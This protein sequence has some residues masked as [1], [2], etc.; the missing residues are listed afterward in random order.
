MILEIVARH[1]KVF[2]SLMLLLL[3]FETI[4]P[5]YALGIPHRK[6]VPVRL[7]PSFSEKR[8][9]QKDVSA[10]VP[11]SRKTTGPS[12]IGGP[13]Q[14]ESQAFHSVNNENMVDLFSG[15]FSYSI[16]LLDIGGYPLAIGYNS[17]ISMDEEASWVGLGWNINP[18]AITRNMRGL[19]D[20]FDGTDTIQKVSSIK[21]NKTVGVTV[22]TGME[23]FGTPKNAKDS[24]NSLSLSA[25]LGISHNTYKGL[26][27]ETGLNASINA[28]A[29][30]MGTFT[31]GLSF[32][33]SSR[34][35][36]TVGTSLAYSL[37]NKVSEENMSGGALSVSQGLAYN[38]RTGMKDLQF[39]LGTR[40]YQTMK[41]NNK[42]HRSGS[43]FSSGTSFVH[44]SFTP[45]I[46]LPYTSSLISV[47]GKV[48]G[49]YRGFMRN[50]YI[51]GYVTKQEIAEEDKHLALPAYGYL[52]YQLANGNDGALLDFNREKEIPYRE[53]PAVP[54][55]GI[56]SYTYDVFAVSGEGTGGVFRAYRGDIG[57]VHDHSIK[58]KDKSDRFSGDLGLG[59]L[60]HVGL[61]LNVNRSF[62]QTGPWKTF[63][64]LADNIR[65]RK[66]DKNFEAVY[67]RN[68]G[69]TTV[70]TGAFYG[71]I[72][73]DDVVAVELYQAGN[74]SSMISTTNLLNRY[75]NGKFAGSQEMSPRNNV[76]TSRDKRT[77]VISYLT[78]EESSVAG[79]SKYIENYRLNQY[80]LH[81]CDLSF[82]EEL[83]ADRHGLSGEYFVGNDFQKFHYARIDS[84]INF[85]NLN[86]VN[87]GLP[88]GL[89]KFGRRWSARW[90]GRLKA[91]VTGAYEIVTN[92]D[93]G[94]R[95]S[96]ND[97]MFIDRWNIHPDKPDTAFVNLQAGQLYN[98]KLEYYQETENVTIRL[99]WRYAG[100]PLMPIP[101]SNL[102][103]MPS[104]DTVTVQG[105]AISL[106]KR[107]NTFRKKN[108][109]SEVSV[110][111]ADGRRYVYGL[112][113]YSLKQ[114][115]KTFSVNA[116]DGN[117]T[118]GLVKYT[119]GVD[120]AVTNQKG[121]DWYF[122]SE[123]VPAYAHSF[124]LTGLMSPDYVDLTGD[125]ISDDDPGSAVKFNYT[126]T[127][128]I[129][130]PYR[131][132]A[133]SNDSATYN[134]GLRTDSRDDKGSYIYGEKELWYVNSIESKNMIATFKL[135]D[136]DD[137]LAIDEKG[138][139]YPGAAK[140]LDE[141]NLYVK[142]DFQKYG[143]A[144]A[145]PVKTVHFE[146]SYDL[147]KGV[148]NAK[149][150]TTGKLTLKRIWFTYNGNR[151]GERNPYI[152]NY[153][154][155]NPSYNIRSYDRWGNYKD[156][157]QNPGSSIAN[158]ITNAEYPY[159]LQDSTLAAQNAAAWTLDSIKLPSGGRIKVDYES[160]DYAFVQNRRAAQ[161]FRIA[162]FSGSEPASSADLKPKLYSTLNE[163]L[164]VSVDVPKAV[165][166]KKELYARYL[167]GM[168]TLFFRLYVE[169]PADKFGK[170][171]EYVSCYAN[172][173]PGNYG[174]FND[175]RTIWFKMKAIT[176]NGESDKVL[177]IYSP[178]AKASRQFLRLNL[179]SK[180]Y[181]GSDVGNDV[182]LADAVK[183]LMSQAGNV[184]DML[185]T[186]ENAARIKGWANEVDLTRCMVRLNNPYHK[187]YGGGLRV[188]RI[189]IY[190]H[191]NA[192][193]K[194]KESVYGH[195]YQYVTSRIVNGKNETISSGVAGFEPLI[196][197]E[198][199]PW[200]L[201]L[202]YKEQVAAMAPVATGYTEK[203]LG[204]SFYPAPS[205][206]YSKV[207]IRT[208][209][210][211]NTRSA[212]GFEEVGFYT[213]Y[214]FPTLTDMTL[215]A[216]SKKRF[217]PALSN[218]LRINARHFVAISQGFKVELNDMNG[219]MR[220]T[221]Y[222]SESDPDVPVSS[223]ENFYKVD[224]ENAIS[225][226]LNNTVMA[227]DPQ[228]VIDT[229]AT[230]G[231]DMELMLDIREQRSVTNAVNLNVNTDNFTF[232]MPPVFIVP[233]LLNLAQREETKF[234]SV[235]A[236]KII[237]RH[238]ILD[239]VVVIDKGSKISTRNLLF[240]SE[241]GNVI[242]A[243][244]QNEFDDPVYSF[245][246]P[247]GWVYD[248][249]SGAYKNINT[250][251]EHVY[252][253][254][255]RIT[256]GPGLAKETEYFSAGDEIL[257]GSRE[258]TGGLDC[259]PEIATFR[260]FGV[261]YAV[262]ANVMSG[263]TPDIYFADRDGKPF[264]GNDIAMKVI[265]S[266]RRN[267]SAVVGEIT[268]LANP[269]KK[270]ATG[271][272][273][274]LD[275][276]IKAVSASA[277]DFSQF[278]KGSDK[279]VQRIETTCLQVPYAEYAGGNGCGKHYYSNKELKQSFTRSDCPR[280][281]VAGEPVEFIVPSGSH[282]SDISQEDADAKA[283]ADMAMNGQADAD[284]RGV[285]RPYYFSAP[286]YTEFTGI[287][288]KGKAGTIAFTYNQE[289]GTDSSLIS[290]HVAD[291]LAWIKAMRDGQTYANAHT[292]CAYG[293][294]LQTGVL[295]KN[296]CSAGG[297][298]SVVSYTIPAGTFE[299]DIS[300]TDANNK[301]FAAAQD[302][303]NAKGICTYSSD[304][305]YGYF[306]KVCG[307]GGATTAVYHEL[308]AGA[309]TS[310]IS[311]DDANAKA[312]ARLNAEGQ[313]K[314]NTS[315]ICTYNSDPVSGVFY[316]TCTVGGTS[317]AVNHSLP[318]GAET[319]T[320]NKEDA[321]AK[322]QARLNTE[323]LALANANAVCS[324]PN[325]PQTASATRSCQT[326]YGS[327]PVSYTVA[328][329]T[330][331]VNTSLA[332]ANSQALQLA[333]TKAQEKAN[334]EGV[335][336]PLPIYVYMSTAL[337]TPVSGT[338]TATVTLKFYYDSAGT[339]PA[340]VSN[341]KVNYTYYNKDCD[342]DNNGVT[343]NQSI[344]CTGT[345]TVIV[346]DQVV[347]QTRNG[348]LCIE[349]RYELSAGTGYIK[350]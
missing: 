251:L 333:T 139:K 195:E 302:S 14:P 254:Q 67:F 188:K 191:W 37:S 185:L 314:A 23:I 98:I 336:S 89:N 292:V 155:H 279:K 64:P 103:L 201:P 298:G 178:L 304:F 287:C 55:I 208:I 107:V 102:Y 237:N 115:E 345:Q 220:S 260:S 246:I 117:E 339:Q 112:P 318:A 343:T 219:R 270:T 297:V 72:G 142:A 334:A 224:N 82:P 5:S 128:G 57:Y 348:T 122:N 265:R 162:G 38:T 53:K 182:D 231:K 239:S 40:Q 346:K 281:F 156:P 198:E 152:F 234:Q 242:L 324:Y 134:K 161:M 17:G 209:H 225:R 300:V 48:G 113:V 329:G 58:T 43:G 199:N 342:V 211:K 60:V 264:S 296:N 105:G 323:G 288:P 215:L 80:S 311:K 123:E 119:H 193:T 174:Y 93:D 192:M 158:V 163:Y 46:T 121:N 226:H 41:R 22:G 124:L 126:K 140:K 21:E 330:I 50:L 99:R 238:G 106:E 350:M 190:D 15:D 177:S 227:I 320:I 271:Y 295:T 273:L 33:N 97:T 291:S 146:Y 317:T 160:D 101:S 51:S 104:K 29:K 310:V 6:N 28:G 200:R 94:V 280:G 175:G 26:G 341:L 96:I 240:D 149:D 45:T 118:D 335:C 92:S 266:G 319:S 197:G 283:A 285:C 196:G 52:N 235:G 213:T 321:N 204:E 344:N 230:M 136:R 349:R 145:R 277:G 16:P 286:I 141:I 340:S 337:F 184:V 100:L 81:N 309:E 154:S 263:G 42:V 78:A 171:K 284:T 290:Q 325:Q 181:P 13:G 54:N 86:A 214:D 328:A 168:D 49:E 127:A 66:S 194:Q 210:A 272:T 135:S 170:G 250:T 312:Q 19:P 275:S 114:K 12:D 301:A 68:P 327:T 315:G 35:G 261:V 331:V 79:L 267:I 257:V 245:N 189:R 61:D 11:V 228:G 20:D 77:Q 248:G 85:P 129:K 166:S 269:M 216:D 172:I 183:M 203:P 186:Y 169:M 56:P 221:A 308:A 116:A 255:G 244:T 24:S 180:A 153:N 233:M 88:A 74:S 120:D 144:G 282:Y 111:N 159:A 125:G 95:L 332:D 276:T 10:V 243:R 75:R 65:F 322:A 59:D 148:N 73:G 187:K 27:L 7:V 83:D 132:R 241:T 76:K 289:S 179:P 4:I 36:I 338:R 212:N 70:N 202:A 150:I 303:A 268:S 44:P 9:R 222:Y 164:Y 223:T 151:K 218:F 71:N 316:K 91:D 167:E 110:L 256:S 31:T 278:W 262:D 2:A 8:T 109:I 63:N 229:A 137:Q 176:E 133:P 32:T 207:R 47:T 34:D 252:I 90:T 217:K 1:K 236:T 157:L 69:E 30:G 87:A 307:T 274:V 143:P 253:R 258:R 306:T 165:N 3:Y 147:C 232:P 249:M 294:E 313:S 293:N 206:G 62:T 326:G 131:W 347:E 108:H 259:S 18:G 299:S 130:N 138:S 84:V 173:E 39:S 25:S 247:A 205:V 305:K